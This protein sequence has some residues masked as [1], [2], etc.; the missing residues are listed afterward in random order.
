MSGCRSTTPS[1]TRS[2][3]SATLGASH[4]CTLA[5]A[6]NLAL[7]LQDQG[8]LDEAEPLCR[9]TLRVQRETLGGTHPSTLVTA[10]NLA[11]LLRAQGKLDE[12]EPLC[13]ETLRVRRET[14]GGTHPHTL[15]SANNVAGLLQ[16]QGCQ[17]AAPLS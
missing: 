6:S 5:S 3:P 1:S 2:R 10:S 17:R 11:G 15:A 16:D 13:R 9:E 8:K 7:L 14:L 4:R 12:A